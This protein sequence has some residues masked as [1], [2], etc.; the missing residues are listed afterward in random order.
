MNNE[1]GSVFIYLLIG[2]ALFA[3]L[4][5]AISQSI[6]LS[7]DSGGGV[8]GDAEKATATVLDIQQFLESLKMRVYQINSLNSVSEGQ[9]DF[10]NDVYLRE[11]NTVNPDNTNAGCSTNECHVFSPYGS[12]GLIPFIF[13][14]A[15]HTTPQ[16]NAILPKNGHGQVGQ[17]IIDGVGTPSPELVFVIHGI[18]P[19]ICNLYNQRQGVTTNYDLTTTLTSIGETSPSSAPAV[20]TGAFNTTNSFG[21]GATIFAGK[22]SFCAPAYADTEDSRLAIWHVLK[23]R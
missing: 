9:I 13:Q 16:S 15:S 7:S 2:I 14:S 12:E 4:S 6:R 23:I 19:T 21:T 17:I 20:F 8:I 18:K 1:K 5:Y 3:A 22:K 11:N 10:Q